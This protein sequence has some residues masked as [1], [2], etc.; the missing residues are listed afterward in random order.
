MALVVIIILII[1]LVLVLFLSALLPPHFPFA[2]SL[3]QMDGYIY[4]LV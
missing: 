3:E 1:A 4:V 2:E